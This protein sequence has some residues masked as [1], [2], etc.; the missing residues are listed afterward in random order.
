MIPITPVLP[1]HIQ[2]EKDR[3]LWLKKQRE[4]LEKTQPVSPSQ[5]VNNERKPK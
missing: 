3:Q 4:K 2:V 1:T 5:R